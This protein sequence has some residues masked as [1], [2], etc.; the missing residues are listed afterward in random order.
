MQNPKYDGYEGTQCKFYLAMLDF[1]FGSVADD[2]FAAVTGVGGASTFGEGVI[3]IG[4]GGQDMVVE[5]RY[6][7]GV[8]MSTYFSHELNLPKR[9]RVQGQSIKSGRQNT[10]HGR[11]FRIT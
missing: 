2:F 1:L 6:V 7:V 3:A 11:H 5:V 10:G 4:E 8:C 9:W